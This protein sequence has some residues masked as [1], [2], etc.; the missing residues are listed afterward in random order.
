LPAVRR[1]PHLELLADHFGDLD[2]QAKPAG[3]VLARPVEMRDAT[4]HEQVKL[5]QVRERSVRHP[6]I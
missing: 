4:E 1:G 6:V 2:R 5:A 3:D